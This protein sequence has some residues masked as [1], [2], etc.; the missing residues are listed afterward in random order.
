MRILPKSLQLVALQRH[1]EWSTTEDLRD[2][3]RNEL[4]IKRDYGLTDSNTK[5]VA[6][7]ETAA[8]Y[9]DAEEYQ[10]DEEYD[11]AINAIF[12]ITEESP[13]AE[14]LAVARNLGKVRRA[15]KGGGKGGF[16]PFRPNTQGSPGGAGGG[17]GGGGKDGGKGSGKT[18]G[19]NVRGKCLNCGSE[20]HATSRCPHGRQPPEKRPCDAC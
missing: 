14:V 11:A 16:R 18:S 4:T 2:W 15:G 17:K 1:N 10:V 5:R 7:L 3:V 13:V 12:D 6:T 19:L 20:E 8:N 9:E